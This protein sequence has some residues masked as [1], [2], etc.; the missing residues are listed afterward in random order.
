MK[1][2]IFGLGM[3][4][5]LLL[6]AQPAARGA[7][8]QS[9]SGNQYFCVGVMVGFVQ[10]Y[11]LG[12]RPVLDTFSFGNDFFSV[13]FLTIEGLNDAAG[14]YT[15]DD[16]ALFEKVESTCVA[17]TDDGVYLRFKIKAVSIVDLA[18]VGTVDLEATKDFDDAGEAAG[19]FVGVRNIFD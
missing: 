17:L 11:V 8:A 6:A 1:R 13:G 4:V 3:A 16:D 7:T 10:E 2:G 14:A 19:F 18:I 9:V 5:F 15:I 12:V